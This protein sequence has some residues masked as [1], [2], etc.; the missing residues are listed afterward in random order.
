[1]RNR[2]VETA[3]AGSRMSPLRQPR[4][5]VSNAMGAVSSITEDFV[6][7]PSNCGPDR[8]HLHD[9]G[10]QA[11][12]KLEFR[13]RTGQN[14]IRLPQSIPLITRNMNPNG[15]SRL[16]P[17]SKAVKRVALPLLGLF[18]T[19]GSLL[20][21][22]KPAVSSAPPSISAVDRQRL[23]R[24]MA[25]FLYSQ[26]NAQLSRLPTGLFSVRENERSA[27]SWVVRGLRQPERVVSKEA[28]GA[29]ADFAPGV[30]SVTGNWIRFY[31]DNPHASVADTMIQVFNDAQAQWDSFRHLWQLDND[32][33][34]DYEWARNEDRF[35]FFLAFYQDPFPQT[36]LSS[37]VPT[38]VNWTFSN[39]F[40]DAI[41]PSYE[42][43]TA[44]MPAQVRDRLHLHSFILQI[45]VAEPTRVV[46]VLK[47]QRFLRESHTTFN[48]PRAGSYYLANLFKNWDFD[49]LYGVEE[50]VPEVFS[51]S[52]SENGVP[53]G[54][55]AFTYQVRSVNDCVI[56]FKEPLGNH[57]PVNSEEMFAAFIDENDPVIDQ[58]LH[59]AIRR[60]LVPQF[61]GYQAGKNKALA[62][63]SAVWT[64]L[65]SMGVT[66]S[67]ITTPSGLTTGVMSQHVRFANDSL[68]NA[69]ANCVDGSVLMAAI[70]RKIGLRTYLVLKPGHCFLAVDPVG[71]GRQRVG[72][73][74]TMVGSS[75]DF[76]KAVQ[77]GSIE[78]TQVLR[79][80]QAKQ[81]LYR[82]VDV[83]GA[84][85][86]GIQPLKQ[87]HTMKLT[88]LA[89]NQSPSVETV[90]QEPNHATEPTL[91]A[92]PPASEPPQEP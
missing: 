6:A 62:Q 78:L 52:V 35:K 8:R 66:Y 64:V 2:P 44:A 74:T 13:P 5:S 46:V 24:A 47:S 85:Q 25:Y 41:F 18:V 3:G 71:D 40:G 38:N 88:D 17:S 7:F 53:S 4:R 76:M 51:I 16:K 84:R 73:E 32:Y 82:L 20:V 87:I 57:R 37:N 60:G 42:I 68:V 43:A 10:T 69:E 23:N 30:V 26:A 67:N 65:H 89:D 36:V 86:N 27:R 31:V 48:I 50:P 29:K 9:G 61:L 81:P 45:K 58:I 79:A 75:S 92:P 33:H 59:E 21:S 12:R 55:R 63:M 28:I 34:G 56:G 1:M 22:C 15:K 70:F 72:I 14:H 91:P 54:Q 90:D 80:A 77:T 19:V 39:N 49:A 83:E 11:H